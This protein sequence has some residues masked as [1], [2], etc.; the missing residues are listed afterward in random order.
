MKKKSGTKK[1]LTMKKKSGTKKRLTVL[2]YT[3]LR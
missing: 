3:E 2:K 1:R